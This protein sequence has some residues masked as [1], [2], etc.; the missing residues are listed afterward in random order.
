[1]HLDGEL[2]CGRGKFQLAVTVT[3]TE[4]SDEW[5]KV[6]YHV[7]D[8]PKVDEAFEDRVKATKRHF[9]ANPY[10]FPSR[11]PPPC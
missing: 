1:M 4:G 3:R 2:W 8:A 9:K 10:V 11:L 5:G 7:F 6:A